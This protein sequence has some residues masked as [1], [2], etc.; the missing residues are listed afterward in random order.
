MHPTI[1]PIDPD[2]AR[3]DA[4]SAAVSGEATTPSSA[5]APTPEIVEAFDPERLVLGDHGGVLVI[6]G[7]LLLAIVLL[8]VAFGALPR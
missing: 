4:V 3:L 8:T 5:A 1:D 6:V 7:L 2:G